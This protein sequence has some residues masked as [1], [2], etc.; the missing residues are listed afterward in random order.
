MPS[1]PVTEHVPGRLWFGGDYN[2]EQWPREVWD[3]DIRL[4]REAEV[5]VV[6]LGVFSWA[7]L[8]PEEGRFDFE[9]LD[10]I[11][12]RLHAA[13][14]GIDLATATASPPP[15]MVR[16]YPDILPVTVD[17]TVLSGGSRQH[18]SPS[19][20]TY[21]RFAVRLASRMAERYGTHPA[22]VAWHVGNEYG[23]HVSRSFDSESAEA[24]R[25]W[26]K[27]RYTTIDRLNDAW[28]TSFWS[29]HY[30][31]FEQVDVPKVAPSTRN[32][33]QVIDFDRFSSDALLDL[34]KAEAE[35]LRAATP[36]IPVTTNFMGPFQP[37]DYW[38][39]AREVDFV[40][41]DSYPDPADPD[42][43]ATAALSRDLMRSLR[44]GQPWI[45]MEQ[46]T[47]AVNWRR[48]N[49]P[50]PAGGNR[51]LSLQAVAHG[52][53]GIMYFQWRQ[54]TKGAEKFHSAM[55]PHAGPS[56]RIFREV[57]ALGAELADLAGVTGTRESNRV[58]IVF[59]WDSW[60][61]LDQDA[62]P[63]DIDYLAIVKDWHRAFWRLDIPVDFVEPTSDLSTY[64][65]VVV[66]A[67]VVASDAG[68]SNLATVPDR[69]GSLV[70][71]FQTAILDPELGVQQGGYLGSLQ[72]VLGVSIDEFAPLAHPDESG[73]APDA[74]PLSS[75]TG[76]LGKSVEISEWSEFVSVAD[77][78]VL[79]TFDEGEVVGSA[80]I[81]RRNAG[82][83]VAWY[84][85]T[86][87]G[88]PAL[89]ELAR[90]LA[91]ESGVLAPDVEPR[92]DSVEVTKRGDLT[93]VVNH[94]NEPWAGTIDGGA[95]D[96]AAHDAVVTAAAPAPGSDARTERSQP[97]RQ[98][99]P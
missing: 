34:F 79:A 84:V 75:I 78:E 11:V 80:A 14:I 60:W 55:V 92:S 22:L 39:W 48:R 28:G 23:C 17:G 54:S 32:P 38:K 68:L 12:G 47:S 93:F 25:S 58:A 72:Q 85:A 87:P 5:T 30:T 41:D 62:M 56:T 13:G 20:S 63:G 16:D 67:L 3:D 83:G 49:A 91:S 94:G 2:P 64:D 43:P 15:W 6:T 7:L 46:A 97:A 74:S 31:S 71:T 4:M 90:L 61:A 96:L 29:Q 21:R 51:A 89:R 73:T 50:K 35:V 36:G 88:R 18:Y 95:V 33:T 66:P 57:V 1:S 24:F 44:Y 81:T 37:L 86:H 59:D 52:A 40:S 76:C 42:S 45:L 98:P 99:R 26:L 53:D 9:W 65:L 10:D 77:A 69:G 82:S 27:D 19:S 70:V 8:E